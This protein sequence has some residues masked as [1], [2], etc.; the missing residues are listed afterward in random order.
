MYTFTIFSDSESFIF[1]LPKYR[2]SLISQY[3]MNDKPCPCVGQHLF[4]KKHS[5]HITTSLEPHRYWW[6]YTVSQKCLY[7]SNNLFNI[8]LTLHKIIFILSTQNKKKDNSHFHFE[9]FSINR[10]LQQKNT[11]RQ[12]F[13]SKILLL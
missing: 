4:K 6:I 10:K 8:N 9:H 1:F 13:F 3:C 7:L 11:S 5:L 2:E 12:C